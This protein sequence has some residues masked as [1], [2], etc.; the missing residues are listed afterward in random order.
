MFVYLKMKQWV[1]CSILSTC[2]TFWYFLISFIL[3]KMLPWPPKLISCSIFAADWP[4]GWSPKYMAYEGLNFL[5]PVHFAGLTFCQPIVSP[6]Y[7]LH[8]LNFCGPVSPSLPQVFI[9][10]SPCP[11]W[12]WVLCVIAH[13]TSFAQNATLYNPL[14]SKYL[15]FFEDSDWG[16][17]LFEVFRLIL[18]LSFHAIELMVDYFFLWGVV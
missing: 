15:F 9:R 11:W 7:S 13:C 17:L 10:S 12:C 6:W 18:S 5:F 8:I 3:V 4:K 14:L 2:Y 16:H 1:K